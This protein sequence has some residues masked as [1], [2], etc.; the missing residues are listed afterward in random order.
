[1]P[2]INATA[3]VRCE[4]LQLRL[5]ETEEQLASKEEAA[6]VVLDA[7][8]QTGDP[9]QAERRKQLARLAH[10]EALRAAEHA[11]ALRR[12]VGSRAHHEAIRPADLGTSMQDPLGRLAG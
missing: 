4:E 1:V 11:A 10:R 8:A 6:S 5:A 12:R 3:S 9:R 7:L 2:S